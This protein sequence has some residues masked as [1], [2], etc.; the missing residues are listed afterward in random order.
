VIVVDTNVLV[1]LLLP[2]PKVEAAER[3]L[4]RDAAWSAPALVFSELRNVLVSYARKVPESSARCAEII[5]EARR[6]VICPPAEES[7]DALV[8]ELAMGSGCTAYDC[9]YVALAERLRCRLV[10]WDK[11]VVVA[12]PQRATTPERFASGE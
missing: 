8:L 12:F 10:T 3:V 1:A 2:G 9:E 5:A 7:D 4:V 6:I 11:Q